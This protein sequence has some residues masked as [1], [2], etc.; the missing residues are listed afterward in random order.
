MFNGSTGTVL[1]VN[2]GGLELLLDGGRQ[3]FLPAEIVAGHR[4]DGTPN[5]SH[6]WA[7]T[8][9][10]AQGG[11]WHHVHLL[12]TPTLDRFTGY[13]GQSRGRQPTH[14]WNTRPDPDHPASLLADDRT[15]SAAVLD[16][17]RRAEPKTFAAPDDP[18]MLD[19][20]LR[21]E[22]AEHADVIR[23]CPPDR[24]SDLDHARRRLACA[25]EEHGWAR[26]G[27]EL[28]ER[29]RARLGPLSRLRRG[30]ADNIARAETA[31]TQAHE[32]LTRCE[33]AWNDA[34][35]S[36]AGAESDV[37]ARLAWDRMHAWRAA[38]TTEIDFRLAHHWADVT[39]RAVRADDPLAFGIRKLRNARDTYRANLER[40]IDQLPPD[41]R[42]A[43]AGAEAHL[44]EDEINMQRAERSVAD[45]RAALDHVSRRHWGRRDHS[46]IERAEM[47][48][49][50]AE[51]DSE[52][53]RQ[54]VAESRRRV[55]DERRAVQRWV[56]ATETTADERACLTA[57]IRDLDDALDNSRA[58]RVVA[59][60]TSP[61]SEAWRVLGAPP[62]TR[63]GL[64][65]WCGIAERLET[66]RDRH[67]DVDHQDETLG[68]R[69]GATRCDRSVAG[70]DAA[71]YQS[72]ALVDRAPEIINAA[73]RLDPTP[74]RTPLRDPTAW[75]RAVVAADRA[76]AL[77]RQAP[78]L[79]C[80]LD[81]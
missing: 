33:Q 1:T 10:G 67:A 46:S 66:R 29:E 35:A 30:G 2:D 20:Q 74:S 9:E 5:V 56:A 72:A 57:G 25:I 55:A 49:H 26:Q 71:A 8:A 58:E 59:A 54:A 16:A 12:G 15:P 39:L 34:Q 44:R 11:T 31:L 22:R 63:G 28:R 73:G 23:T 6:A 51:R 4:P 50:A 70:L 52:L 64:H 3:V 24:S 65:A 41:R 79:D 19:R 61:T 43:L 27:L 69:G 17:M 62:S 32:R 21:A 60:A 76:L 18:W 13:L 36:V 80:G 53:C 78:T 14:T 47:A 81:L 45:T 75:R 38:R 77:E 48:G 42:D 68:G 37:A 40:V 7:R